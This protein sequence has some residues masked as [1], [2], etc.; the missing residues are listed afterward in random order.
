[1]IGQALFTLAT[2]VEKFV[3][4][5]TVAVVFLLFAGG[6]AL[7]KLVAAWQWYDPTGHAVLLIA[8]S[9]FVIY[10]FGFLW[11][12]LG[13]MVWELVLAR[14]VEQFGMLNGFV[15]AVRSWTRSGMQ[16]MLTV[17]LIVV[18]AADPF[19]SMRDV[20]NLAQDFVGQTARQL[21]RQVTEQIAA[22]ANTAVAEAAAT[23][24]LD[25]LEKQIEPNTL[26]ARLERIM[27][28]VQR[29]LVAQL[30]RSMN[31]ARSGV[32][33]RFTENLR[34]F[35]WLPPWLAFLAYLLGYTWFPLGLLMAWGN[36]PRQV[37]AK[38]HR[39][40]AAEQ[41]ARLR[42]EAVARRR[43]LVNA[44][45]GQRAD[46]AAALPPPHEPVQEGEWRELP[47]DE[48]RR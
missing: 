15:G 42:Q 13:V 48:Q 43:A 33:G 14:E 22:E 24:Q 11:S 31:S 4:G 17:A 9:G 47:P 45:A 37:K 40:T 3:W 6:P 10:S 29:F 12:M 23:G 44:Y 32:E 7:Q 41:A 35:S 28:G 34:A 1:M 25:K 16:V 21:P 20:Q 39:E 19:A 46:E 30:E 38:P 27:S 5:F 36:R 2:K 18:T 26:T 8:G